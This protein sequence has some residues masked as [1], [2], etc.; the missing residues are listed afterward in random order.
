MAESVKKHMTT[1]EFVTALKLHAAGRAL[2]IQGFNHADGLADA[3]ADCEGAVSTI[4]T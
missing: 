3:Q 1:S 2:S 4:S